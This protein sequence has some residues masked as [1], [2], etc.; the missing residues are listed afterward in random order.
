MTN[1]S[2]SNMVGVAATALVFGYTALGVDIPQKKYHYDSKE[3]VQQ[4]PNQYD[5]SIFTQT[6]HA[7]VT[8]KIEILH[9]FSKSILDNIKDIDPEYSALVDEEFW[10]LL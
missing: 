4:Y 2:F 10:D 5:Y 9:K 7:S 3:P 1:V 8:D 6:E